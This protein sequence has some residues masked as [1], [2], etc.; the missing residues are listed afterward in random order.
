MLVSGACSIAPYTPELE[1]QWERFDRYGNQFNIGLKYGNNFLL[2][3]EDTAHVAHGEAIK[4]IVK[5]LTLKPEQLE[6]MQHQWIPFLNNKES[7]QLEALTGFGKTI[8]AIDAIRH[9]GKTAIIVAPKTD[10]LQQFAAEICKF[11]N[12]NMDDIGWL[13]GKDSDWKGRPIT[14]ATVQTL[15]RPY[16]KETDLRRI[17]FCIFDEVDAFNAEFFK[18]S[19]F[20]IPCAMRW[21]MSATCDRPDGRGEIAVRHLGPVKVKA[22]HEQEIPTIIPVRMPATVQF[23]PFKVKDTIKQMAM[24]N[25][26]ISQSKIRNEWIAES[27]FYLHKA[28]R[29]IIVFAQTTAH[30]KALKHMA[31]ARGVPKPDTCLYI[32]GMKESDRLH[33]AKHCR[34]FFATY[35]MG[36]RSTNIPRLDTLIFGTPQGNVTQAVGRIRRPCEN[37]QSPLVFDIQ[38][39]YS[40]AIALSKSRFKWYKKSGFPIEDSG[41]KVA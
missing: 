13:Q 6:L 20:K 31:E 14:M 19:L 26:A 23:S 21:G 1:K 17:G 4:F 35:A 15:S 5:D 12:I 16:I 18:R 25:K 40:I 37:K 28:G 34:V 32:G 29:N 39:P 10:A 3:R 24:F 41:A 8:L 11:S 9:V 38:D 7:G 2:P 33:Y 36:S 27:V 22:E 30:L